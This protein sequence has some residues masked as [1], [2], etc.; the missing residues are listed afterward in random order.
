MLGGVRW[1]GIHD[2]T[3]TAVDLLRKG[4]IREINTRVEAMMSH[5]LFE[6]E[7]YNP[8]SGWEKRHAEKNVQDSLHRISQGA[9]FSDEPYSL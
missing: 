3:K 1:R 7:F 2:N 4:K 6:A 8:A 9:P 5:Q